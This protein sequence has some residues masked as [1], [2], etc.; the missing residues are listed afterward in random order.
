MKEWQER[1][2]HDQKKIDALSASLDQSRAD[3]KEAA[4]RAAREEQELQKRLATATRRADDGESALGS[5]RA[6]HASAKD[7]WEKREAQLKSE[8]E[9]ERRR[10]AEYAEQSEAEEAE[11]AAM[12]K[13][14]GSESRRIAEL[15][16]RI[17]MAE[18]AHERASKEMRELMNNEQKRVS[19]LQEQLE[20][21][22]ADADE[23]A[24]ERLA[25]E[26][27]LQKRLAA[28]ARHGEELESELSS[29]RALLAAAG[30]DHSTQLEVWE[31]REALL[32]RELDLSHQ[33]AEEYAEL[34]EQAEREIANLRKAVAAEQRR[35]AD[36]EAEAVKEAQAHERDAKE[37]REAMAAVE[38]RVI[39]L[40]ELLDRTHAESDEADARAALAEQSLQ[41]KLAAQAKR[42]EELES[43]LS[44][45]RALHANA[46]SDGAAQ[47]ATF[48]HREKL[49]RSEVEQ[50]R[51][52]TAF[53]AEQAEE[54]GKEITALKKQVGSQ[55]RR[56]ADLEAELAAADQRYARAASEWQAQH[57]T[58]KKRVE[59]LNSALEEAQAKLEQEA[60]HAVR[61]QEGLQKK[62]EAQT[63]RAQV[64]LHR[65]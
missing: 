41:K 45:V 21:A 29:A 49:L 61:E 57:D 20:Q 15:E 7:A 30:T 8:L 19:Q 22:R 37:R 42:T 35:V 52:E 55:G 63:R 54:D 46:V 23:A 33:K 12:R 39:G 62:L 4:K 64:E 47:L 16:E 25:Q 40:Q 3:A 24:V 38:K 56:M 9:A 6:Q 59:V 36:L 13:Q 34:A 26:Q 44:S 31:K 11:L 2:G 43:E 5:V 10:A 32:K 27:S 1:L 53:F 50:T 17:S 18:Q 48:E 14:L 58:D 51:Q 65:P 28:E 60:E